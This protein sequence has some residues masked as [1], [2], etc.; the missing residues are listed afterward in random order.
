MAAP[1]RPAPQ[2]YALNHSG[3]SGLLVAVG[4][5]PGLRNLGFDFISTARAWS[6]PILAVQAIEFAGSRLYR[7]G[8]PG[9]QPIQRLRTNLVDVQFEAVPSCP[10]RV[11]L[12][13]KAVRARQVELETLVAI[14]TAVERLEAFTISRIPCFQALLPLAA[15][16]P[17]WLDLAEAPRWGA[18]WLVAPRDHA[19]ARFSL[20]G[21]FPRFGELALAPPYRY[22]LVLYRLTDPDWSYVEISHSDDCARIV[23]RRDRTTAW[24][25]FG[26][27]GLDIEKGVILRGRVRGVFLKRDHDTAR[28]IELY[29]QLTAESPRLSV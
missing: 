15:A 18:R 28:A 6:G 4:Q 16:K 25:H 9:R 12:Y 19:A 3:I 27:F 24:V 13:W 21:R 20:D 29:E 23:A 26:L 7:V 22:P 2:G 11:Q 8:T 14:S 10:A 17:V 5:T 1:W